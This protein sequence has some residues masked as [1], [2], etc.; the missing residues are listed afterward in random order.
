MRY[1]LVGN[2]K[3]NLLMLQIMALIKYSSTNMLCRKKNFELERVN[4]LK[5]RTHDF[6][7]FQ[8]SVFFS[9]NKRITTRFSLFNH[10]GETPSN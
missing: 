1:D 9:P 8:K 2:I 4:S 10:G 5:L 7:S 3:K 6:L